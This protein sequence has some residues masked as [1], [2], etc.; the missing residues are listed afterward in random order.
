MSISDITLPVLGEGVIEAEIVEWLVSP[1]SD[2]AKEQA[3][4]VVETDKVT[5]EILAEQAGT[6]VELLAQVGDVV[7]VGSSIA[8]I[9]SALDAP[10]PPPTKPQDTAAPSLRYSP[11][12]RRLAKQHN[13]DLNDIQG[14]GR[15]GRIVKEDV[16]LYLGSQKK[17][18]A[19]LSEASKLESEAP[20]NNSSNDQL[21]PLSATR[22]SIAKHM[23]ESKA[24]SP[25]AS[26]V[27]D[28]DFS[29][30]M[31]HRAKHKA[32]Y[33]SKGVKL[34]ITPYL[35]LALAQAL[36]EYPLV[37]S[38]WTEEGILQKSEINIGMAAAVNDVL[39]VPVIHRA[40]S[41]NLMGMAERVNDLAARARTG[42]LQA[43]DVKNGTFTLTNH[44]VSG[45]LFGTPIINQP[46]CAIMGIGK[47][48][49]TVRVLEGDAGDAIVIRPI[50]FAGFS[51]DHRIIDGAYADGFMSYVKSLIETWS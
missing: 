7:A 23:V 44:G 19:A 39:V 17:A 15:Q 33:A 31:A 8:T 9:T 10:P 45:S 28:L 3:L 26:T 18:E 25:H 37:N 1:N 41:F 22:R 50:A 40:M 36:S 5:T 51:F 14:S 46:Q 6:I 30:V 49:K 47:I 13:I 48:Q 27:F 4:L 38:Q 24:L 42:K 32:S 20:S 35:M 2:I 11:V 34:T 29:A 16:L 43:K 21:I 12:V